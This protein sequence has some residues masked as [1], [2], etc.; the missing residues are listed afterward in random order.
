MTLFGIASAVY[1]LARAHGGWTV[2][3]YVLIAA[4]LVVLLSGHTQKKRRQDRFP[5][6]YDMPDR[7][8]IATELRACQHEFT[9]YLRSR[10]LE[11]AALSGIPS[12]AERLPDWTSCF[13]GDQ[14]WQDQTIAEFTRTYRP[15]LYKLLDQTH[16]VG[17]AVAEPM[18]LLRLASSVS[19]VWLFQRG[20]YD[21]EMALR[22]GPF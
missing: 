19:E 18:E 16:E 20:L 7:V 17:V 6:R 14:R 15:T 12:V 3:G 4:G 21:L 8:R 1:G 11:A 10:A 22:E 9:S 13:S 5:R 2:G